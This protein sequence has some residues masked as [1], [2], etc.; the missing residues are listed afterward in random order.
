MFEEKDE[1]EEFLYFYKKAKGRERRIQENIRE[2]RERQASASGMQYTA[3]PH[4]TEISDLSDYIVK[5][6]NKCKKL[7]ET[8]YRTDKIYDIITTTL[9]RQLDKEEYLVLYYIYLKEYPITRIAD[10]LNMAR[11]T[12]YLTRRKALDHLHIEYDTVAKIEKLLYEGDA[13]YQ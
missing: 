5:V 6:E 2:L 3:M 12:V 8:M 1:K 13:E 7:A 4:G 9:Q 10:K 11:P